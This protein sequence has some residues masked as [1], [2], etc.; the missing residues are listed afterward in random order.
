MS[1]S[2][3]VHSYWCVLNCHGYKSID[4]CGTFV[5]VM[6]TNFASKHLFRSPVISPPH[7]CPPL[8]SQSLLSFSGSGP[9]VVQSSKQPVQFVFKTTKTYFKARMMN[10]KK[11]VNISFPCLS[12]NTA[13]FL[14]YKSEVKSINTLD[15]PFWPNKQKAFQRRNWK[16]CFSCLYDTDINHDLCEE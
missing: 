11:P 6:T 2:S 7:P 15:V 16:D 8:L 4:I 3:N 14:R 1:W 10:G 13:L 5:A 9:L 12:S